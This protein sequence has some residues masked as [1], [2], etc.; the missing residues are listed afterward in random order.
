MSRTYEDGRVTN[1]MVIQNRK[2][3]SKFFD[4]PRAMIVDSHG[5]SIGR[6]AARIASELQDQKSKAPSDRCSK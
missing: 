4:Y 2:R 3:F 6:T 5:G 1:A